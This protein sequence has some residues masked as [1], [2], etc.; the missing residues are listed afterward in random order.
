VR[1]LKWMLDRIEGRA[2]ATE[3]PIGCVPTPSS[4]T[5]DGLN[6]SRDMMKELLSVDSN[7][8]IAEDQ[9]IGE[10]FKKFGDRMPKALTEEH[11]ALTDRL[12][13]S[14]VAAK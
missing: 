6:I 1:V 12:S 7:D 10:F 3:T 13:R 14:T 8:W 11:R 5:L 2:A 9:A 4:L